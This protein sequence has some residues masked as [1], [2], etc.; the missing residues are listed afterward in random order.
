MIAHQVHQADKTSHSVR[1]P[2]AVLFGPRIVNCNWLRPVH[3]LGECSRSDE[4][5]VC[6]GARLN[7]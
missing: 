5:I 4:G 1:S 6:I 3:L 7:E 2:V